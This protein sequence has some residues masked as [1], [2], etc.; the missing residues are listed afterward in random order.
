M[1]VRFRNFTD[2]PGFSEDFNK[3][4]DFLVDINNEKVI[5]P[6]FLWGRWEWAFSLP[7]L[8]TASLSRIGIWEDGG[9]IAAVATYES[10]LGHA[11]FLI[12]KGYESLKKEML[13]YAKDNLLSGGKI[14]ALIPDGDLDFQRAAF[15]LG[16]RPTQSKEHNAMMDI[17]SESLTYDLPQGFSITSLDRDF[18]MYKYN[19]VLWRGFNHEGE[20]PADEKSIEERRISVSGPHDDLRLKVAVVSLKGDFVSYCGMWCDP[21]TSYALVEPVATDPDFRRMGLGRAAVLEC[22]RRC[23][24]MG[25][26]YAYV[27]SSQQ[28][29]YSIGF[30]PISTE[31]FW[32]LTTE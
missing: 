16:F 27:G 28:F 20:P 23:G 8:D 18:D 25:A 31:T 26:K 12:R 19:R 15:G 30:Y 6:G 9:R 14:N 21:S 5:A 24:E 22:V 4:R 10:N 11:Y 29:Y 32:E 3:V 2:T 13:M 7:F 17:K 1:P